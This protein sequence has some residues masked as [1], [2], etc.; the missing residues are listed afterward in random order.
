[1]S[2][3]VGLAITAASLG[4]EAASLYSVWKSKCQTLDEIA[5]P[6]TTGSAHRVVPDMY[7]AASVNADDSTMREMLVMYMICSAD[8]SCMPILKGNCARERRPST[9]RIPALARKM[10]LLKTHDSAASSK[11]VR[12]AHTWKDVTNTTVASAQP[13]SL[14][15]DSEVA[16]AA[17]STCTVSSDREIAAEAVG[18]TDPSAEA[19]RNLSP[20]DEIVRH[21]A[22]S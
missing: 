13:Q 4:A 8:S 7:A 9:A 15:T 12:C 22:V 2:S 14:Q 6:K 3:A 19:L 11:K 16:A 20:N 21:S 18:N 17:M 10:M 5:I 1:M